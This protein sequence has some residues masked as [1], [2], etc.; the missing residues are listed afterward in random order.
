M[1]ASVQR[2]MSRDRKHVALSA[3]ALR[4]HNF[5][6]SPFEYF[7]SFNFLFLSRETIFFPLP[8]LLG[9]SNEKTNLNKLYGL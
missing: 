2:P 8:K 6:F 5:Y 7:L 9:N 4:F 1:G 3:G